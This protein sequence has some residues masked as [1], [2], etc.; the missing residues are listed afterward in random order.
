MTAIT[1][2][3]SYFTYIFSNY[4]PLTTTF[5]QPPKCTA[6][7]DL[8]GSVDPTDGSIY[9]QYNAACT[10]NSTGTYNDECW[11]DTTPTTTL[12]PPAFTGITDEDFDDYLSSRRQYETPYGAFYSPGLYC[13]SGWETV[14]MAARDTSSALTSSG[15]LADSSYDD[16]SNCPD[17]I[18]DCAD[19]ESLMKH[20]L[21]PGQ[22]MALC[23]PS[24]MVSNNGFCISVAT[25]YTVSTGC[26]GEAT[27]SYEYAKTTYTYTNGSTTGVTVF[28]TPTSTFSDTIPFPTTFEDEERS[29]YR[30]LYIA[31]VVTLLY[32]QSD[33]EAAAT[34]TGDAG[35]GTAGGEGS[36]ETT[37]NMATSLKRASVWD[38]MG[39]VL[40]VWVS[41]MVLGAV[42]ILL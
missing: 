14:G 8:I 13:P 22:T 33:L 25:D 15:V 2:T 41:C 16:H 31:E 35:S 40:V 42:M 39:S 32:H 26:V 34:A 29:D 10:Y 37:G 4:G 21:Q 9:P 30:G 7:V 24:D 23:C 1:A 3:N 5:T 17:Q 20:A 12:T 27:Y 28:N 38:G 6:A 36:S 18:Y 19:R 11:P